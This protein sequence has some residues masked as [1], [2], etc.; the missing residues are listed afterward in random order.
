MRIRCAPADTRYVGPK[1]EKTTVTPNKGRKENLMPIGVV[2]GRHERHSTVCGSGDAGSAAG[3][4]FGR[5]F[6]DDGDYD[7]RASLAVRH[8]GW[9]HRARARH[10]AHD[11]GVAHQ[12]L[13]QSGAPMTRR[14]P[15]AVQARI[16][17]A[18]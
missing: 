4:L 3:S 6:L 5:I 13:Y 10:D 14:S 1:N 11:A 2:D 18:R 15:A 12:A 16:A 8:S 7:A 9:P 17:E